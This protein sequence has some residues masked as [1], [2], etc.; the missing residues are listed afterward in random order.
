LGDLIMRAELLG[1]YPVAV[2]CNVAAKYRPLRQTARSA[3][4]PS[5]LG[6][7]GSGVVY[8]GEPNGI[9]YLSRAVLD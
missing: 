7:V 2:N 9:L 5:G 3:L 4:S 6:Y 8:D 1:N